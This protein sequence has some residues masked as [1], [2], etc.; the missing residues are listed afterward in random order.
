MS[1]D[2]VLGLPIRC[3]PCRSRIGCSG[4][5]RSRNAF[6][7]PPAPLVCDGEDKYWVATGDA[8]W[9]FPLMGCS[10]PDLAVQAEVALMNGLS[11][12]DTRGLLFKTV[13]PGMVG[14]AL[15]GQ[16]SLRVGVDALLSGT[17]V[18]GSAR[19]GERPVVVDG[20]VVCGDVTRGG[21]DDK[22]LLRGRLGSR[23]EP[24]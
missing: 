8:D 10:G 11:D 17:R 7:L 16:P 19:G 14:M 9:A 12:G 2:V 22:A 5:R 18:G 20:G 3:T 6:V 24:T 23:I 21:G 15:R 1:P 4:T 13:L